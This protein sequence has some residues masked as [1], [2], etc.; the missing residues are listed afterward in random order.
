MCI[1]S[2]PMGDRFDGKVV[3]VAGG[4]NGIGAATARRLSRDGATVAVADIDVAGA[5]KLAAE[6]QET[7]GRAMAVGMDLRD[8]ASRGAMVGGGAASLG[9]VGGLHHVAAGTSPATGGRDP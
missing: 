4:A 8:E 1:R 5:E 3:I 7:G 2:G 6:L 9:P